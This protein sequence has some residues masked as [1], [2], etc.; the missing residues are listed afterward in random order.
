MAGRR[1]IPSALG[2][3]A[4]H[5]AVIGQQAMMARPARAT[6]GEVSTLVP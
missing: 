3:P 1:R 5:A 4:R 6:S 2:A